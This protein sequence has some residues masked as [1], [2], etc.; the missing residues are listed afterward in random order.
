MSDDKIYDVPAEWKQRGFIDDAKYKQMY[1]RSV[2]DPNGFWGEHGKR[3]DWMRPFTKVKNTSYAPDNVSIKWFE[4][5]TL[6]AAYNCIDRHLKKRGN[7]TAIIWEGD[8]PKD[9][10][11]FKAFRKADTSHH[12]YRAL[13]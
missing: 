7:Q 4:D 11:I 9:E 10:T 8:D 6:N 3:V 12:Q 13:T 1:E 5:G 2:K